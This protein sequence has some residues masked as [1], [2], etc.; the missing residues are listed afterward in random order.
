MKSII[1]YQ[2]GSSIT[3]EA[4][5][6]IAQLDGDTPPS[7]QDLAALREWM[8]RS[9]AH[10]EE[11]IRL[12]ELWGRLELFTELA[13]VPRSRSKSSLGRA[14]PMARWTFAA[15]A[16]IMLAMGGLLLHNLLTPDDAVDYRTGVGEQRRVVLPDGSTLLLNTDSSAR[17]EYTTLERRVR[18]E[19]GEA[20]FEV[21]HD[22][23]RPFLVAAG[24]GVVRAVGTAFSVRRQG[25][26][27]EV[28]VT[29]GKVELSMMAQAPAKYGAMNREAAKGSA[30]LKAGQRAQFDSRVEAIADVPAEELARSLAWHQGMLVF[31]GDRLEQ[32]VA[33][34]SRYTTQ[35]IVFGDPALGELRVGG[36]FRIGETEGLFRALEEGFGLHV[37]RSGRHIVLSRAGSDASR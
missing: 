29:E 3:R 16:T 17:V 33:E 25:V 30:L 10:R 19:R 12:S 2:D 4:C 13:G 23:A 35:S 1:D 31:S 24:D 34:V 7:H 20:H 37:Q 36:Q 28:S 27:A 11:I 22:T 32:V 15:A 9:P 5:A 18:L 6:W 26:G 21:E 14:G 8:A